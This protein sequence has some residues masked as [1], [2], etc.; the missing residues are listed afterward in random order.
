[1]KDSNKELIVFPGSIKKNYGNIYRY[2]TKKLAETG[3]FK[4]SIVHGPILVEK[5]TG[6]IVT[7][8]TAYP[9]EEYFK[10][11]ETEHWY[12]FKLVIG[13]QK[14]KNTVVNKYNN[15]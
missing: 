5:A 12:L 10:A 3:D 15:I 2:D 11:F 1:M 9:V 6:R 7:F 14:P 13:I 8:G 4:Y